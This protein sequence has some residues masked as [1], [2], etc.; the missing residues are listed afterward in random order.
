MAISLGLAACSDGSGS[1]AEPTVPTAASTSS[2][3]ATPDVSIIPETIDEPYLNAVL[4][5]LDEVDGQA[6]RMIKESKRFTP[7]AA[8]LLNAIYSDSEL[9]NQSDVWFAS[10]GN[11][12]DLKGLRPTPGNRRTTVAR[13]IASSPSCVWLAVRRD[14]SLVNVDPGPSRTEYVALEPLDGSNDPKRVNRTAWMITAD[15]YRQ[16]GAEPSNPCRTA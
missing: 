8:D 2:T 13:V 10:L 5:A 16:D 7:E 12:P 6:T 9:Q 11:D 4:A 3:T 14:Y 1:S 15:G